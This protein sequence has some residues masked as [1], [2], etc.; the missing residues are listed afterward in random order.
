MGKQDQSE[1]AAQK[2]ILIHTSQP[3][4]GWLLMFS[5]R[6]RHKARQYERVIVSCETS[7]M[8]LFED[9]TIEFITFETKE[10]WRDRFFFRGKR[11]QMPSR[12]KQ[13]YPDAKYFVPTGGHCLGKEAEFVKLGG[14][15]TIRY[16]ILIHAR[17]IKRGDWIDRACG[18]DHNYKKWNK[19][20]AYFGDLRVAC[21]GSENG[22]RYVEGT[23][24]LRGASLKD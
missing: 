18:G 12:L 11:I 9:F 3:E 14:E 4:F 8:Y 17:N 21:V 13:K 20:A 10:G 22:S 1:K 2:T 24:D 6:A 16:D 5:A 23:E 7:M 15:K 19:V